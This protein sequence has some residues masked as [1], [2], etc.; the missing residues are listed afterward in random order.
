MNFTYGMHHELVGY[1]HVGGIWRA[2]DFGEVGAKDYAHRT[3]YPDIRLTDSNI[4]D[5]PGAGDYTVHSRTS[6][7]VYH[8]LAKAKRD[9][10]VVQ[11]DYD[12]TYMPPN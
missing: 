3:G 11:S 5:F 9:S 7:E 1:A 8:P 12:F 6:L 4:D 2:G 10:W